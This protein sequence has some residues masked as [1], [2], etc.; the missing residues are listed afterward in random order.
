M[1]CGDDPRLVYPELG[2]GWIARVYE[3]YLKER[4]P[5]IAVHQFERIV[6]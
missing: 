5:Y 4:H 2:L 1:S 6:L 3:T